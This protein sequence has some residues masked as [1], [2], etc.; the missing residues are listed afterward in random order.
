MF[1][2]MRPSRD[3]DRLLDDVDRLV[4]EGVAYARTLSRRSGS[5]P[6]ID[7]YDTG[8]ELV[9]KALVPGAR[10]DE[11]GVA[12]EKSTLTLQGHYGYSLSEDDDQGLVWH[13]REIAS[14]RFAETVTLPVQVEIEQAK[15]TFADGVLTLVLPKVPGARTKRIPV[16]G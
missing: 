1:N 13:R 11:I 8:T 14:G 15:A 2:R 5:R 4:T 12:I 7:L 10:P 16:N 6:A 9:V 3:I